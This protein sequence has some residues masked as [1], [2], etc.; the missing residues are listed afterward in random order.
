MSKRAQRFLLI[1]LVLLLSINLAGCASLKKKFTRKKEIKTKA[2][3]YHVRKYDVK[4]SL[5]L[6]EKHY[7]FWVNWHKELAQE[8]G[9]NS[10]SDI[11]STDEMTSNLEDMVSLLEDNQ[12]SLLLPHLDEIKKVQAIIKKG[13][14]TTANETRI[15]RIL[16]TEYRGI[17]RNFSPAKMAGHI[18][19]EFKMEEI[20][21]N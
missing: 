8:L 1:S 16:E 21:E 4:P 17:K 2:P 9:Q 19:G 10:K 14:M 5:E 15:R 3:F 18:R 20:S 6:Y 7:I 12:A 13:N 11:R